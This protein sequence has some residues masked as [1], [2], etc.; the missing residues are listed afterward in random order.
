MRRWVLAVA[1]LILAIVVLG[2]VLGSAWDTYAPRAEG[3]E[4]S[5]N[6]REVTVAFCGGT[7]DTVDART[8]REDE[9]RVVVGIRLRM[10]RDQF[11][12]GTVH[13]ITFPLRTELGGRV[14]QDEG[15]LPVPQGS[16]FL[17]PG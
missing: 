6:S 10:H 7:A 14:V 1:L 13:R 16:Q 3:Y 2:I 4:L 11:E 8:L 9:R 15:G 5:A 17:C 12:Y